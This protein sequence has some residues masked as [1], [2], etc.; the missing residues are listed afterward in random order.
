MS[1]LLGLRLAVAGGREARLRLVFIAVG[2]G[3]GMTLLLLA[4]TA[5]SAVQGRADR[6]GWQDAAYAHTYPSELLRPSSVVS[7]DPALFLSVSDYYDG[8]PMNR[9]YVAALGADPPVPPG[10]DRLPGPG[11][12]AASPALQRLLESTPDEQLDDRFPGRVTL[13]IGAA[14]L[15]HDN[16]LVAIIGRTPDQL[17]DVRSVQ[18]VRSFDTRPSGYAFFFL[19]RILLLQGAVMVL[20]PV[21]ILIVAVSRVA[22]AQREQRLAAIRLVGATRLQTATVAAAETGIA[23]VAGSALAWATYEAGR[24]VV[25]ATVVFQG[26]HFWLEDV[27]VPPRYLLLV[28]AGAPA[29]VMLTTILSLRGVQYSP[30]GISRRGRRPPS[31]WGALPLAAGIGGQLALDPLRGNVSDQVL[32]GLALLIGPLQIVGF[33]LIGPWLCMIA[34]KGVALITRGVP[35]LIAARRIA[36]DPGATFRAIV[37]VVL[38]AWV[39]TFIGSTADQFGVEGNN[40]FAEGLRPGVVRVTTGGVAAEKVAPLLSDPTVVA[41]RFGAES[42]VPCAELARVREVSCPPAEGSDLV[43]PD[44]GTV[45]LAVGEVYI[46]TDGTLAAENR[47][48]TRAANLVPNALINSDR[49]PN[50]DRLFFADLGHLASVASLF[51]LLLGACSLTAGMI[52]GLLERRRPFA[53]LRAAGMRI[54][55]LRRVVVLETAATMVFTSA[56]G[57]GLGLV[58]AYLAVRLGSMTWRWPELDTYAYMGAGVLAALAFSMFGLPLLNAATRHDAVR[59]E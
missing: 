19:M 29:L 31:A 15:A 12:V 36:L 24:R 21:V 50:N 55:E 39:I 13:T 47:A 1:L 51:V 52:G 41:V 59:Y 27:A 3:V 17:R 11:E 20:V 30:L 46:P 14:G 49:D 35:G 10:L 44:P 7:A 58:T 26:G 33:V 9:A 16:E 28:L 37:G 23:A 53:L 57:V 2:V 8:T 25:S 40:D 4:L 45:N 54:G 18:E 38:A 43:E 22:A 42:L 34:G 5:Q 6:I 48:R 32:N 56:V